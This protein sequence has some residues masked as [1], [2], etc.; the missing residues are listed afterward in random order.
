MAG[1]DRILGETDKAER[2]LRHEYERNKTNEVLQG[3]S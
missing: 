2:G 1:E 3:T